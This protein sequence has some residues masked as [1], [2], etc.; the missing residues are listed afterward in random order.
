VCAVA[1]R[2]DVTLLLEEPFGTFG[3]MNPTGHAALYFSRVCAASPLSLRRCRAGEAGVV[4]SRYH[5]VA[6]YDWIAV[7]VIPY[8]YAVEHASQVPQE[9]EVK[10]VAALRDGYRRKHLEALAPDDA[11]G[12]TPPGDW[13]QL[14]GAAYDRTIYTFG[15]RTT[16]EQDDRLIET[17][18]AQTNQNQFH[19]L[20]HN[21]ADF[22]RQ[23]INFYYPKAIH[24]SLSADVGITTP[25]QAAKCL[26]RYAKKHPDLQLSGYV[27]PQVPGSV[28]RSRPVRNVLE[29][30]LK[31]KRYIVPLA[32]LAILHPLF[33]GGLAVA[34]IQGSHFNPRQFADE[35]ST[36]EPDTAVR[37]LQANRMPLPESEETLSR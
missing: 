2:A 30:V 33:G 9:I 26:V 8:L 12:T 35:E 22:V 5:R 23:V 17:F 31:S 28:P 20:S 14:V 10:D 27:I 25:K 15:I 6:G 7:P 29:A 21:C 13:I 34:W 16:E 36:V 11:D 24:R 18:N 37:Q 3:G 4:I 32:P 1:A 19:L